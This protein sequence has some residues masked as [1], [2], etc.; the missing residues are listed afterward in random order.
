MA[1]DCR[2]EARRAEARQLG[3]WAIHALDSLG[4]QGPTKAAESSVLVRA[5]RSSLVGTSSYRSPDPVRPY[6][7]S[8]T[9]RAHLSL[10]PPQG[11]CLATESS[12][13]RWVTFAWR[14]FQPR[15]S[16]RTGV[17]GNF[18]GGDPTIWPS[19]GVEIGSVR[20]RRRRGRLARSGIGAFND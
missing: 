3:H 13:S 9:G 4:H 8:S 19:M 20:S 16:R 12:I 11:S 1:A 18:L 14:P 2:P 10:R 17:A 5:E 6:L 15:H 7:L